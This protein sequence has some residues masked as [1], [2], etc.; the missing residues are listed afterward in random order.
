MASSKRCSGTGPSRSCHAGLSSHESRN[1][2]NRMKVASASST[3]VSSIRPAVG[4]GHTNALFRPMALARQ[5]SEK[6]GSTTTRSRS[7]L[8]GSPA[9]VH[10]LSVICTSGPTALAQE[11]LLD[12]REI[13]QRS[14]ALKSALRLASVSSP[15]ARSP[16]TVVHSATSSRRVQFSARRLVPSRPRISMSSR[17]MSCQRAV[18]LATS[19][20]SMSAEPTAAPTRR[21]SSADVSMR[22][23]CP[24]HRPFSTALVVNSARRSGVARTLTGTP[25][26]PAPSASWARATSSSAIHCARRLPTAY[27]SSAPRVVSSPQMQPSG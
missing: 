10:G 18:S 6:P 25:G 27:A 26:P 4:A 16:A 20:A 21:R 17:V 5:R 19:S 12:M 9:R 3:S 14:G 1:C 23:L 7:E 22:T 13:A 11:A 15:C 2:Q 24:G 8:S